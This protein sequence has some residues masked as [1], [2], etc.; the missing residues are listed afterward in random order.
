MGKIALLSPHEAH[1]IAAGEVVERPANVVKELVENALDAGATAITVML[2]DGG[3][4]LIRVLDNGSG[5]DLDDAHL[6]IQNHATSKITSVDDLDSLETFGFR[7]EA[8]ASVA[9]VSHMK[10]TTRTAGRESAITLVIEQGV[11]VDEFDGSAN[12]GTDIAISELFFNVPARQKFLKK[13]ETELRAIEQ[14]VKAY[15]LVYRSCSFTL[16]HE[17]RQLLYAPPTNSFKERVAQ[18]LGTDLLAHLIEGASPEAGDTLSAHKFS[19]QGALCRPNRSRY[20]RNQIFVFVNKRWVK[21]HKLTQAVIKG[22]D[23]ILP[24]GQYPIGA[25]FV[26]VPLDQVD[27]NIH[28]RKEEV[29]FLHPRTVES[30]VETMVRD[31]LAT[32]LQHDLLGRSGSGYAQQPIQGRGHQLDVAFNQGVGEHFFRPASRESVKPFGAL[33]PM[34]APFQTPYKD[35]TDTFSDPEQDNF[36]SEG[37]VDSR[38]DG[39]DRGGVD[40]GS[41][42]QANYSDVREQNMPLYEAPS[43]EGARVLGQVFATYL[44]VERGDALIMIDQHA[45]HERILYERFIKRFDSSASTELLFPEVITLSGRSI[46]TM[47]PYSSLFADIGIIVEPMGPGQLV[48]KAVPAYAK[49][50]SWEE[51]FKAV[52]SW[53]DEGYGLGAAGIRELVFDKLRAMMACKAAVKAG[54]VLT[55]QEMDDLVRQLAEVEHATTCPHGRPTTW[56]VSKAELERMFQRKL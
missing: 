42:Q 33:G 14:V 28:P 27:I 17:T 8:L 30:G 7:G 29:Q 39:V 36:G 32:T 54:D 11:I 13:R 48:V 2:E 40:R 37:D 25:V 52:L 44:M 26:T 5:M 6:C 10:L 15:A 51:V 34:P 46:E 20:D 9:A 12:Q 16:I 50:I 41:G 49:A 24:P 3:K 1:K 55:Q 38:A 19:V 31:A 35:L 53:I 47:M 4:R 56:R 43:V 23:N 18:V 21:N 22:Y 45:A